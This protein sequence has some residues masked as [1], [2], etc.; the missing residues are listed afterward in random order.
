MYDYYYFLNYMLKHSHTHP[1][2]YRIY[3]GLCNQITTLHP[4]HV[5]IN[6]LIY[7]IFYFF[8]D[9]QEAWS[10]KDAYVL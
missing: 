8:T 3:G 4:R 2:T 7:F 1:H 9:V 5:F 10:A 6:F